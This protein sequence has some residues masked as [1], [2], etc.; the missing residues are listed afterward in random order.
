MEIRKVQRFGKS[1]LMVSLPAD[2]VKET[3]L[4]PGDSVYIEPDE[5]GSIKILPPTM[6]VESSSKELTVRISS[7]PSPELIS[8]IIYSSYILGYD[9]ITVEMGKGFLDDD[10][11]KKIK[12]TARGLIGLEIVSQL[13][14]SI[15]IQSFLD[16]SKYTMSGLITRMSN[17]LKQMLHYLNLGIK[18]SSRAFLQEVLEIE[19][20]IDRLYFLSLRQLIMAQSNR[21]LST[22]IGVKRIQIVG[23]R[24][25]VKSLEEAAD[26]ISEAATDI[27][28]LSPTD[29][30]SLKNFWPK[31]NTIIEQTMVVIDHAIKVLSKEDMKMCNDVSE[32][33]R[34]IRRVLITELEDLEKEVNN[35]NNP[36]VSMTLR[37]ITL[38]LYNSIRRMEPIVEIS[39][40]R[41]IENMKEIIIE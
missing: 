13:P 6:K 20:E 38:R 34:T 17:S 27:L 3:S 39:F 36:A 1:T 31:L 11:I 21:T 16:P 37:V 41:A 35:L 30:Q 28:L 14:D 5:D 12:E 19:K 7:Q 23:N 29:I 10:T 22:V 25:L 26:E 15:T 2:W 4:S 40:N 32:E 33:L 8:K 9:K 18:E 24:I